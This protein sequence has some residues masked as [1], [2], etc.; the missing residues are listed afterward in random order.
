MTNILLIDEYVN[1]FEDV[2][3]LI[4]KDFEPYQIIEFDTEHTHEC[5][6]ELLGFMGTF[7]CYLFITN[8]EKEIIF[9]L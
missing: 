8:E 4:D 1:K 2:L 3:E 5:L 6:V 9:N 7:C